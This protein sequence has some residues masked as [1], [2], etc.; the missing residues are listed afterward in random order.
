MPQSHG[1]QPMSWSR[2]C[3]ER[4]GREPNEVARAMR[5]GMLPPGV[6]GLTVQRDPQGN[7]LPVRLGP[8]TR[9]RED[10]RIPVPTNMERFIVPKG[11]TKWRFKDA[12]PPATGSV[13]LGRSGVTKN[14]MELGGAIISGNPLAQIDYE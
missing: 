2:Y 5:K 3:R 9:V 8:K 6:D 1:N 12:V 11:V 4:L 10:G 14:F 7:P 13:I